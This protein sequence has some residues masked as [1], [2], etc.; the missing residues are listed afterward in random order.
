MDYRFFLLNMRLII[1]SPARAWE[2]INEENRPL[3]VVRNSY[4]LPVVL[5]GTVCAFIGSLVFSNSS[6]PAIYS[7]LMALRYLLV[8][9]IVVY[10]SAIILTE[11]TKALD[12]GSSFNISFK[13][14]VY[15][16][17][18][19]FVCQMASLLFESLV[20][21]NV[22]SLYGL[23]IFW[24]GAE[25][26]LKPPEHKRIPLLVA[27]LV[28]IAELYIASEILLSSVTERIYFGFFA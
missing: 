26:L 8:N 13:L 12:L 15:S 10:L 9:L 28:V 19:L 20:F 3:K 4:F 11:I 6:L 27:S 16:M 22:L 18:P 24:A 25:S 23:Y 14:I 7:I 5:L 21:V 2:I 1:F 17:T